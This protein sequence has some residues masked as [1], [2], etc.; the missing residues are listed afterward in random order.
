M[1][2]FFTPVQD[3]RSEK[4]AGGLQDLFLDYVLLSFGLQHCQG[5]PGLAIT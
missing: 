3:L 2:T 4:G 1:H 5:L